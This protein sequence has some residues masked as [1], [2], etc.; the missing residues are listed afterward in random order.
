MG[1]SKTQAREVA[2]KIE[3]KLYDG[4]PTKKILQ[5]IFKFLQK[6]KPAVKHLIDL[7][8]GIS[9][10]DPQPEFEMYI[11]AVL[12]ENGFDV[13]PNQILSG[14][15]VEHEVD[16]IAQKDGLT[17]F[18]EVKH[19]FGYHTLTG[20]DESRIARAILED[21][22]ECY[23][24]GKIK[25]KVDRAMIVTNTRYSQHAKRYGECRNILQIG[26]NLPQNNSLQNMIE[27]QK[28]YPLTCLKNLK[29]QTRTHLL[30]NGI[31]L[32]KQLAQEDPAKLA[33][34]TKLPK[35]ALRTIIEKAQISIDELWYPNNSKP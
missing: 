15:C 21:I 30:N 8:R 3:K 10:M 33:P 26:W 24:L 19:H 5:M 18:V 22:T 23:A 2:E 6:H 32:I 34:K 27:K 29:R 31:V 9:L 7:R 4:I 11:R 25:L 14:N 35:E 20:L 12:R 13:T 16:A 17:Y 28:L 1:A